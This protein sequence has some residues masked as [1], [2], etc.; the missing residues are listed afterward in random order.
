MIRAFVSALAVVSFVAALP[1]GAPGERSPLPK[2]VIV[3][4][5]P[6]ADNCGCKSDVGATGT[7]NMT[8]VCTHPA[9]V[10][11]VEIINQTQPL[12]LQGACN[13]VPG[14]ESCVDDTKRCKCSFQA[15]VHYADS[16]CCGGASVRVEYDF[17]P[18]L[19][20]NGAVPIGTTQ[21]YSV[22]QEVECKSDMDRAGNLGLHVR[23]GAG[24]PIIANIDI[25]MVCEK[26][27]K[28]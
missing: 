2:L 21:H 1:A 20:A 26:C 17:W 22:I 25:P 9:G 4:P 24:T 28:M 16:C 23:C 5:M 19:P 14:V 18:L 12:C 10:L 11:C 6:L 27:K 3:V 13:S 8:V 7:S 15:D